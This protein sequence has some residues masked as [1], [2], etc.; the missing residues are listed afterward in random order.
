MQSERRMGRMRAHIWVKCK[1]S[2]PGMIEIYYRNT[3]WCAG[4][5]AGWLASPNIA[6]LGLNHFGGLW[7]IVAAV[8]GISDARVMLMK[9]IKWVA[10]MYAGMYHVRMY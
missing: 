10:Q 1:E 5:L 3:E 4:R 6:I 2:P 9:G 7:R 8:G